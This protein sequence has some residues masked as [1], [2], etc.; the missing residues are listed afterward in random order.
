M[1]VSENE[2]SKA[3]QQNLM[4]PLLSKLFIENINLDEKNPKNFYLETPIHCAADNGHLD[5]YQYLIRNVEEK[6]PKNR[7]GVTPLQ[8]AG[9]KNYHGFEK[10]M[11]EYVQEEANN[12]LHGNT[13]LHFAAKAGHLPIVK[14]KESIG[15]ATN[16]FE[17]KSTDTY[18]KVR[19]INLCF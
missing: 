4:I 17:M 1:D 5:V 13:P 12:D 7:D 6:N 14:V 11:S 3:L 16:K 15:F 8:Y 2:V 18:H 9:M 10:F 19:S